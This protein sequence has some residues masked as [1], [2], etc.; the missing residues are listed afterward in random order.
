MFEHSAEFQASTTGRSGATLLWP[1]YVIST[2]DFA[3]PSERDY[4]RGKMRYI[5]ENLGVNQA[6]LALKVRIS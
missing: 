6:A 5:A 4:V 3:S 1:L 2:S